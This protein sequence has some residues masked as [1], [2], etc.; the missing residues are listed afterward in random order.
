MVMDF[1]QKGI[2]YERVEF[3]TSNPEPRCPCMLLLDTSY[4]MDGA[5]IQAL[6][7]GLQ[8]FKSALLEDRLT[9]LRVEVAIM[10]FGGSVN[11]VQD[12]VPA[13]KFN[14]PSLSVSGETPMGQAI[15]E[16]LDKLEERKRIYDSNGIGR[17]R[18]W[19][20]LITDGAPTDSWK[21]AA[22]RVYELESQ[23]KVAFFC[24]GV[25]GADTEILAQIS[26]RRQPVNLKGLQ[27]KEMFQWLANSLESVSHSQ[28]NEEVPL[29][30]P[31]GPY[32]W[33]SIT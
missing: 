31:V 32:G 17:F 9:M 4:S 13:D 16:A 2:D 8:T 3:D 24:V 6:N 18:P 14:P 25:A 20:F 15:D 27:F 11:L 19:V 26:K 29:Q 10:T 23:K 7:E 1:Q 12:F 5:R 30:S 22:Q 28:L 33:G 21:V